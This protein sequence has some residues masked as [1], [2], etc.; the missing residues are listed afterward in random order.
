[1]RFDPR[2]V[3]V[4]RDKVR[5]ARQPRHPETE[6]GVGRQRFSRQALPMRNSGQKENRPLLAEN[7]G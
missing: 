3:R 1:M 4:I 2:V 5:L 7:P 6:V